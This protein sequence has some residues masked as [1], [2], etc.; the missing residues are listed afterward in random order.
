MKLQDQ[1]RD[2]KKQNK[3]DRK[4]WKH[5]LRDLRKVRKENRRLKRWLMLT[6]GLLRSKDILVSNRQSKTIDQIEVWYQATKL[7]LL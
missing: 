2:L 4:Q 6:F 7:E 5:E 1:I 3:H